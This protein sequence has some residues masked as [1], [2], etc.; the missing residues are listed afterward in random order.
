M[1]CNCQSCGKEYKVDFIVPNK[2]WEA[3]RPNKVEP[4]SF[5]DGG[6]L[7]GRCIVQ[8]LEKMNV[9]CFYL[10]ERKYLGKAIGGE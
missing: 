5:A 4:R 2:I 6:L 3:I 8:E 9:G 1:S 10:F 7:C